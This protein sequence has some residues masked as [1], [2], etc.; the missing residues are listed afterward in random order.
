MKKISLFIS[1]ILLCSIFIVGSVQ[2]SVTQS[3][4]NI[5]DGQTGVWTEIGTFSIQLNSSIGHVMNGTITLYKDTTEITNKTITSQSNGTQS[6]SLPSLD[7]DT[8]YKIDVNINDSTW[9]NQTYTFITANKH[10]TDDTDT[11]SAGQIVMIG[12]ILTI[13]IIG[14]AYTIYQG[15]VDKKIDVKS[16]VNRFVYIIVG[17]FILAV[18]GSMI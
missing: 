12:L 11:F 6:L 18:I 3:N 5:T 15:F 16:M 4:S 14:F 7:G 10:L 17:A 2:A 13:I 1:C 8:E 9:N